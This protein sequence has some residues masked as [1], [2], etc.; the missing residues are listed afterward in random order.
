MVCTHL[1][2]LY[3][4]CEENQLRLGSADLIHVICRQCE[5]EETCPSML[6]DE[7]DAKHPDENADDKPQSEP[8][9]E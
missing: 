4:F 6:M 9:S 1:K 3:R 2:E 8:K 7:Y 5:E